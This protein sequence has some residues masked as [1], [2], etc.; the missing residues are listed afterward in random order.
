MTAEGF[1][2]GDPAKLSRSGGV[3]TGTLTLSDGSPAAS[4]SYV[5]SHGGS[6]GRPA[7]TLLDPRAFVEG[8]G[9][10]DAS[11]DG[12]AIQQACLALADEPAGGSVV[13]AGNGVVY[14]AN[15]DDLLQVWPDG[16]YAMFPLPHWDSDA[17][18]GIRLAGIDGPGR[19]VM[20]RNFIGN[21]GHVAPG[22]TTAVLQINYDTPSAYHA[23]H[24]HP[25]VFGF[26]DR[27]KSG[28]GFSAA[29]AYVDGVVIRQPDN[30]SMCNLNFGNAA[31][32]EI[33]DYW[34]D[35]TA[36][37]DWTS[38]P[39]HPTGIPLLPP[40]TGNAAWVQIRRYGAWGYY[41]GVPVAEHLNLT[42]A[43][44]VAC[45]GAVAFPWAEA[46]H[47]GLLL[48]VS[49]E[50]C[51]WGI[52]GYDPTGT[53]PNGGIIDCP[54]WAIE[55]L[56]F[57]VEDFNRG[58][59]ADWMYTPTIGAHVLDGSDALHATI[60]AGRVN[61]GPTEDDGYSALYV[62]GGEQCSIYVFGHGATETTRLTGTAPTNPV[63]DPP[64]APTI[65][66]ATPG[67]GQATVTFTPA[68][69]G[70]TADSFTVTSDP[71]GHT[72]TGASSPITVT[73]LTNG[74]AY[75]FT[76]VATNDAGNSDPS[77]ASNSVTPQASGATVYAADTFA[78]D[79]DDTSLGT[80]SHGEEWSA[81]NG[82]WGIASNAGHVVADNSGAAGGYNIAVLDAG[83]SLV[84]YMVEV[85]P[86]SG[87]IDL[88]LVA[89]VRNVDDLVFWDISGDTLN[90]PSA[91]TTR[92][93]LRSG[94]S[95]T[96]ITDAAM[97][98][99]T[100]AEAHQLKMVVAADSIS[101]YLDDALVFASGGATG[102]ES[103]TQF[104][105]ITAAGT[106][107][108]ASTFDNFKITDGG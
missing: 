53:G 74:T 33:T 61:S 47:T 19:A 48:S 95:F 101:C 98:T 83:E 99:L 18:H 32:M 30:P 92:L 6:G 36:E 38:E 22:Q 76:V 4:Q 86:R 14:Q 56:R 106:G 12:P 29:H 75:A 63:T 72:G 69:T 96:G 108:H 25:S 2:G 16:Q 8:V 65:G 67:D 24:G 9:L 79:D 60:R 35:T 85:T 23:T 90:S 31:T 100:P 13:L 50:E 49:A 5:D 21:D 59:R 88:G 81:L 27:L 37:P 104:G 42:E 71:D 78:R 97:V 103:E 94:G 89:L 91:I 26:P 20:S 46:A 107:D 39:T 57:D 70:A 55:L 87:D 10:G 45:K 54:G 77:V 17:T 64:D 93:F 43:L 11:K 102:L 41:I 1:T 40:A 62:V 58:G 52:V 68:G 15:R 3:M 7:P 28:K 34:A 84:T 80:S 44:I 73:G 66:T 51:P 82:T 105:L